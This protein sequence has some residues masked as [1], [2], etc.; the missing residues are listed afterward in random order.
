VREL[1][2]A[3]LD[4]L[5]AFTAARGGAVAADA[6]LYRADAAYLRSL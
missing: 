4:E 2:P 3:R 1:V 6:R 5:A